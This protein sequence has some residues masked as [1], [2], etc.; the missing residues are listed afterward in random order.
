M[1]RLALLGPV[2]TTLAA[3]LFPALALGVG[4][5]MSTL[6]PQ[7][8]I[9]GA[10]VVLTPFILPLP[11]LVGQLWSPDGLAG[12][13]LLR[14]TRGP[15][16][17]DRAWALS[18][19]LAVLAG[20][21]LMALFFR[22]FERHFAGVRTVPVGWIRVVRILRSREAPLLLFLVAYLGELAVL[23]SLAGYPARPVSL[24]V[25]PARRDHPAAPGRQSLPCWPQSGVRPCGARVAVGLID[26]H[27]RQRRR[28]RHGPLARR[29]GGRRHGV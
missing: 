20:I 6:K 16:I 24:P 17:D 27:C 1:H 26:C 7:H 22:W 18:E 5:R 3:V 9:L 28:V 2:L 21:L 12:N 23:I 11:T 13:A 19:Q 15:V 25:G 10:G 14:G 4:R 8:L 29:G